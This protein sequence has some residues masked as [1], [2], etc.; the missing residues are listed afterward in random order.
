MSTIRTVTGD[1]DPN[2]LG[3][4]HPHEHLIGAPPPPYDSQ[5]PDLVLE[6]EAAA[7]ASVRELQAAGGR[8]LVEMTPIDYNRDPLALQRIS[9]ATGLHII[10]ITGY[11][12]DKFCRPLVE[13]QSVEQ[14]TRRFIHE[15]KH[16]MDGTDIRAG[17]IKAASSLNEITPAEQ[18][19]FE[20]AAQAQLATGALISTHTEAGTMALE[21]IALLTGLGVPADRILIGHMDRKLDA[22]YHRAV[23]D[24]GVYMGFDQIGKPQYASDADHIAMLQMLIQRG[25]LNQIMLSMDIA[26]KRYLPVYGGKP[27]FAYLLNDFVPLLRSTEMTDET[28]NVMLKENPKRALAIET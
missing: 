7:I 9:Q 15:I 19:V 2:Q 1:I 25:H 12:K 14:L 4:C 18:K 28:I 26:R 3:I 23:A 22:D 11:L 16:G 17:A 20:A 5:D 10:A 24:M 6:D 27:G 8:A 13:K 21:Q